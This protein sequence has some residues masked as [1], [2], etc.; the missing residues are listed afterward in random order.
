MHFVTHFHF[1]HNDFSQYF[2]TIL[3]CFGGVSL[4]SGLCATLFLM[5]STIILFFIAHSNCFHD[6]TIDL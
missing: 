2:S 5:I 1:Y 3:R 4:H 6:Y